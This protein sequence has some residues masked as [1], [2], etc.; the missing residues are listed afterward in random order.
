M[1]PTETADKKCY[2]KKT[3]SI[4]IGTRLV[5]MG[6]KSALLDTDFLNNFKRNSL[7]HRVRLPENHRVISSLHPSNGGYVET[8]LYRS[9]LEGL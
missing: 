4:N 7:H 1:Y 8:K 9:S 3:F 6:I 2:F 5:K